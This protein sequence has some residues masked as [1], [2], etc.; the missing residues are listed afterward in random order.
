MVRLAVRTWMIGKRSKIVADRLDA[1]LSGIAAFGEVSVEAQVHRVNIVRSGLRIRI[2]NNAGGRGCRIAFTIAPEDGVAKAEHYV[3]CAGA[4]HYG[5]MEV[6]AHGVLIRKAL[7]NR[8]IASLHV[9]ERHGVPAAVVIDFA[10]AGRIGNVRVSR[11]YKRIKIT[12]AAGWIAARGIANVAVRLLPHF[13][14]TVRRVARVGIIG[15]VRALE[16]EW[17]VGKCIEIGNAGIGIG[18]KKSLWKAARSAGS[19]K[20]FVATFE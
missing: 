19:Q 15:K 1:R 2:G 14:Q 6:I 11:N 20:I 16:R 17:T 5:L 7:Q 12:K 3:V 13:K 9:V 18:L 4:A 8:G 10:A